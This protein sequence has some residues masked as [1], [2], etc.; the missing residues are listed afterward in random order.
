MDYDFVTIHHQSFRHCTSFPIIPPSSHLH[1]LHNHPHLPSFIHS[2]RSSAALHLSIH[3]LR[4][5]PRV[6]LFD[7]ELYLITYPWI[8]I[9][10]SNCLVSPPATSLLYLQQD[11]HS[12]ASITRT[13]QSRDSSANHLCVVQ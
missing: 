2:H 9:C 10:K 6:L 3:H 11:I 4:P 12:H 5:H 1:T 7:S 8:T 13:V